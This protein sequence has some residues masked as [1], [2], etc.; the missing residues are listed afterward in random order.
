MEFC[1]SLCTTILTRLSTMTNS[2]M[3]L[4]DCARRELL[5]HAPGIIF[6]TSELFVV[7]MTTII[8]LPKRKISLYLHSVIFVF[9]AIFASA[10]KFV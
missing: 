4:R 10:L 7:S 2:F 1:V 9:G 6:Q 8:S 5:R 3:I